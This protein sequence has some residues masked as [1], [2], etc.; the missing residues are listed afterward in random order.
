M[1]LIVLKNIADFCV[2]TRSLSEIAEH[3]ELSDR[4]KMKKCIDPLFGKYI[5]MTIPD[6]PNNPS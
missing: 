6:S 5:E 1:D 4:Y 2:E 3:L